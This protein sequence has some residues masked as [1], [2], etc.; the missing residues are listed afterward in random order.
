MVKT[1]KIVA[2]CST[3]TELETFLNEIANSRYISTGKRYSASRRGKVEEILGDNQTGYTVV[4]SW[5]KSE[6]LQEQ[7]TEYIKQSNFVSHYWSNVYPEQRRQHEARELERLEARDREWESKSWW[8]KSWHT[9]PEFYCTPF[10]AGSQA[11][12]AGEAAGFIRRQFD[13]RLEFPV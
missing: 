8:Y 7:I 6:Y 10:F 5:Y 1:E 11:E 4:Y 3:D 2:H 13:I 9:K 12:Y